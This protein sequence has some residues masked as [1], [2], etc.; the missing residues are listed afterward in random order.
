MK[1]IHEKI[2]DLIELQPYEEVQN[3]IAEP[4]RV[5]SAYRFTNVTS[6]LIVRWLDSLAAMPVGSGTARALA[7]IRGVGKSH[8]I[9]AFGALAAMPEL[10]STINDAHVATSARA[11][12]HKRSLIINVQ[13]GTRETL[14]EE[15][16]SA[17]AASFG[18]DEADWRGD[19]QEILSVAASRAGNTPLV[20][21]IDTAF[22]R[23]ARVKRDDGPLLSELA[24][25][26][27]N[28]NAFIGLALDDDISG[29]DGAN[30]SLSGS[31][32]I[33]YLDPEHLYQIADLHLFN[34]NIHSR[35]LLHEIYSNLRSVVPGFNWS[36]PR[37]TSVYPVHPIVMD[38]TPAVRFY[39]PMFAFLP[40]AA[41]A[42]NRISSRPAQSLVALDEVFDSVEFHLR[43][44]EDL[45]EAFAAYDKTVTDA[46]GKI[47]V[48][49]RLQAKIALK[50]LFI[51]S[52]D[53][54]GATA[55]ELGA[56]SLIYD[57]ENPESAVTRIKE[58]FAKFSEA[59]STNL[60]RVT[61]ES[62]DTR[63]CF[64]I[65][66][67]VGFDVLL[68]EAAQSV[69]D[70]DVTAHI[71]NLAKLRFEDW[72]LLDMSSAGF[73]IGTSDLYVQWR[74]VGRRGRVRWCSFLEDVDNLSKLHPLADNTDFVDWEVAFLAPK[75]GEEINI[76][77]EQRNKW[78]PI[79]AV[80]QPAS[81][82][83]E[84]V[85]VLKRLS[86]L[87]KNANLFADY[88]E[89]AQVAE[90]TYTSVAERI[91][92]RIYIE[93][94]KLITGK[95]QQPISEEARSAKTLTNAL[96]VML[97]SMLS[98]RYPLHPIF[99]EPLGVNEVT[100][101]V[102]G[103]FGGAN[104]N[105]GSV[106]ELARLFALPLGLVSLRNGAF[107]LEAGDNIL[108]QPWARE[109]FTMTDEANG[110]VVPVQ[111][112]FHRLRGEPY[113]LLLESQQI[114]LA[115]LIAQRRVELI[116]KT[117]ERI[118]RRLLDYKLVWDDVVGV[119][120][121]ASLQSSAEE[122]TAWVRI[123]TQNKT[124]GS[125]A[126]PAS[127][128]VARAGLVDWVGEWRSSRL[129]ERFE[130]LPED[131]VVTRAWRLIATSAQRFGM[132]AEAIE[133]ALVDV[134]S[135]EEGLQR[136]SDTFS[137]SFEVFEQSLSQLDE[138]ENYIAGLE[139]RENVRKYVAVAEPTNIDEIESARSQLLRLLDDPYSPFNAESN[140][141]FSLLWREFQLRYSQHYATAH[142]V[143]MNSTNL[144]DEIDAYLLSDDWREFEAL[145]KLDLINKEHWERAKDLIDEARRARCELNVRQILTD[146]P[147]CACSF[148][149]AKMRYLKQVP[150]ELDAIVQ[151]GLISYKRALSLLNA[152]I[153][154]ALDGISRANAN[155]NLSTRARALAGAFARGKFPDRFSG[156]E[157]S[158]LELALQRMSAPPPVRVE[159]PVEDYGLLTR[160]ELRGRLNQ[161]VD[162]L[163]SEPALVEVV[164]INGVAKN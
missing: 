50:G 32:Y 42:F 5:L 28:V 108:R 141:R 16:R 34:K 118:G 82:T 1:R 79:F 148:R 60:L 142:A 139:P 19:P 53:G 138:L 74:G 124:L 21:L 96:K 31:Y 61:Q 75:A 91:W 11:L 90:R 113:G 20:I 116:S 100:H 24:G 55:K 77:Q 110:E 155:T 4:A 15:L 12:T 135:L 9:A 123:L 35:K 26:T 159:I 8:L 136:V 6:D 65:S 125:I 33:D 78:N 145:S 117:N 143:T 45:E 129:I 95:S 51:L 93:E 71:R 72:P 104:Q 41:A 120:R 52:L 89:A 152:P 153:A 105:A 67:S 131:A 46:I 99:T 109:I 25:T 30:V 84:D 114:V 59:I 102:A 160:E 157:I 63:Y 158:L 98:S 147:M 44:S 14:L 144:K 107:I 163:P 37:F 126:D 161:W 27:K 156:M 76:T 134:I 68:A 40:F 48:M 3:F 70:E 23:P 54:R 112:V 119:A 64:N 115:A 122:L 111:D 132:A 103:L 18:N 130:A 154:I 69:S 87:R 149:L 92:D 128:D 150:R 80:W 81:L 140:K 36:E 73:S 58:M 101:L 85:D 13:R 137:D 164:A 121:S 106:Q 94:G 17:F 127:R 56:A 151:G 162:D 7:G 47:P 57:E 133:T 62:G 38:I 146:R 88:G 66:K 39:A 22:G 10:S 49:Q 97:S 2:K 29:A 86:A 83:S 43:K